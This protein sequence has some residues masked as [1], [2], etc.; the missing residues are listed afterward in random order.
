MFKNK[1]YY[2]NKCKEYLGL[3]ATAIVFD[4][5]ILFIIIMA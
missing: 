5:L 1:R 3:V 2:I 4:L